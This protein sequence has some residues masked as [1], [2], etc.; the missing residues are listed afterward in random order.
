MAGVERCKL[1]V[2]PAWMVAINGDEAEAAEQAFAGCSEG[3]HFFTGDDVGFLDIVV[4]WFRAAEKITGQPVLDETRTPRLAAWVAWFCAHEAVGDVMP[5]TGR[6]V[7]FGEA[8]RAALA[9]STSRP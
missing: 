7:E 8:L 2:A 4:G 5:D 9:A 6:L 3:R 1:G